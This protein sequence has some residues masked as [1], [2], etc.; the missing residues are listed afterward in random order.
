MEGDNAR[1]NLRDFLSMY[2]QFTETCFTRCVQNLNY[3][4][5]TPAEDSCTSNCISKLINVNH[6]EIS[7]YMEINPLNRRLNEMNSEEGLQPET[8]DLALEVEK[9][10]GKDAIITLPSETESV[11]ESSEAAH[12]TPTAL[13][14]DVNQ[15]SA[16]MMNPDVTSV[17]ADET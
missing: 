6:R 13:D 14:G 8:P 10:I 3:R 11:A 1:R 17:E 16:T 2:N 12:I 5:L 7:T 4:V 15:N 9:V